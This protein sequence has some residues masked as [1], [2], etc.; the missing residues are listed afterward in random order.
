MRAWVDP[1]NLLRDPSPPS[2]KSHPSDKFVCR[3][4]AR[5]GLLARIGPLEAPATF[6]CGF[7]QADPE[8]C[9]TSWFV[10]VH[11]SPP[12]SFRYSGSP[13]DG[14]AVWLVVRGR[15]LLRPGPGPAQGALPTVETVGTPRLGSGGNGTGRHLPLKATPSEAKGAPGA[16][17]SELVHAIMGRAE[18]LRNWGSGRPAPR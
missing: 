8:I 14:R 15:W 11:P 7:S 1:D 10:Q 6:K 9:L 12:N 2:L 18:A 17:L 16:I 4:P 13:S 3:L 5:E